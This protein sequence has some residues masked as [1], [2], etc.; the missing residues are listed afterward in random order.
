MNSGNLAP[1]P[2]PV[3]ATT[4]WLFRCV[5][6]LA[7]AEYK[8]LILQL[9]KQG[10]YRDSGTCPRS[11]GKGW[12]GGTRAGASRIT[13]G[14]RRGRGR[15][16]VGKRKHWPY[17]PRPQCKA[18][19]LSILRT[20]STWCGG[21]WGWPREATRPPS[22]SG[23]PEAAIVQGGMFGQQ[24]RGG[25]ASLRAPDKLCALC[26]PP[27]AP[28]GLHQPGLPSIFQGFQAR[29]LKEDAIGKGVGLGRCTGP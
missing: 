15:G 18:P 26:S 19:L 1:E 24:P 28:P 5:G 14:E 10:F 20:G 16:G 7:V 2:V 22:F 8:P 3:L 25:G 13:V 4:L 29:S 12:L 23:F 17:P 11:T 27:R 9:R 6:N 21:G